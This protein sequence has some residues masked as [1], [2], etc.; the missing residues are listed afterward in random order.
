MLSTILL[1]LLIP[2]LCAALPVNPV[3]DQG[4]VFMALK[5]RWAT[6]AKERQ[7]DPHEV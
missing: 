2:L 5:R 1:A 7:S 3:A 4:S 6:F